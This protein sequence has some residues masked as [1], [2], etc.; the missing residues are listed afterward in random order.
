VSL[1]V[2]VPAV[3]TATIDRLLRGFALGT[4][5]PDVVTL[6]SNEVP[7][8]METY[9]LAVR[10]LRFASG[11]Y[12]IGDHDAALRRNIGIFASDR[13]CLLTFDDDQ[14][15]PAGMVA[16]CR[17]LLAERDWFWGHHR[18]VDIAGRTVEA[19]SAAPP[20]IGRSRETAVNAWHLWQSCYGGLFGGRTD[21]VRGIGGYDVAACCRAGG[22]DQAFGWR[23]VRRTTGGERVFVHEPP[24]AWHPVP[25]DPPG[26]PAW[27]N[28]CAGPH[29][30]AGD[31][32]AGAPVQ[33]CRRCPWLRVMDLRDLRREQ[34]LIPY[35]PASVEVRVHEVGGARAKG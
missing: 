19:L 14:L 22:E 15:V 32:V 26:T 31:T 9:G 21:V 30:A 33:R 5:R 34:P 28:L 17:R 25:P 4:D 29:D 2:I 35:D 24:F 11:R 27:T 1:D 7:D 12:P 6:V 13:R 8:R 23:L 10:V 18:Y 3:R 20:G 16:A